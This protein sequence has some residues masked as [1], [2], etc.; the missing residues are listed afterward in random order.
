MTIDPYTDPA[1]GVLHNKLGLTDADNLSQ[2]ET[3]LSLKAIA[4]LSRNP[5]PGS[6]DLE[7]LQAFHRHIFGKI[8]PWTGEIRTVAI[9]KLDLYCLPQYIVGYATDLF[10]KLANADNY[11][12]ELGRETFLDRLTYYVA[13]VYAVHPFREGNSRTLR[14]FFAQLAQHAGWELNWGSL[15]QQRSFAALAATLRGETKL[16]AELLDDC[17]ESA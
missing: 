4:L 1:T 3:G 6:Y 10:G 2:A 5:L 12:R 13:E 17:L 7:H 8:Y 14:A 15:N 16:L 9:A 11:L